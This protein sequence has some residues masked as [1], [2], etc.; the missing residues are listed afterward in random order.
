MAQVC[1]LDHFPKKKAWIYVS[2]FMGEYAIRDIVWCN[3]V[4]SLDL[5]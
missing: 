2:G 4:L 5:N 3:H 1:S